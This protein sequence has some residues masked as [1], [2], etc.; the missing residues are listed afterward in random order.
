[1]K[2]ILSAALLT[3]FVAG[4][5]A[6]ADLTGQ[7]AIKATIAN[8][9]VP[10]DCTFK[11]EGAKLTGTCKG[12]GAEAGLPITGDST[13]SKANFSYSINV[14]GQDLTLTYHAELDTP[15]AMKGTIDMMGQQGTFTGA[16]K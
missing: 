3:L 7:W 14:Q 16:K 15:T 12:P 11:Q 6:A 5:A 9:D 8:M 13:G 1:M 10:L 4:P 2:K